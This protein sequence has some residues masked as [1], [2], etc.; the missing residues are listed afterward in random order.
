M[1]EDGRIRY[2]K[3]YQT[4]I[5]W[6]AYDP[7]T[8][9]MSGSGKDAIHSYA[10]M[11]TKLEAAGDCFLLKSFPDERIEAYYGDNVK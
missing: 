1:R 10:E 4:P 2:A 5:S 11:Q 8:R 9:I 3:I 7:S 6:R